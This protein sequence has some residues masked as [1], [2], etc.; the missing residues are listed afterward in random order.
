MFGLMTEWLWEING[1]KRFD[2]G[3]WDF[4]FVILDLELGVQYGFSLICLIWQAE[5]GKV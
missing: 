1:S 5:V 3:F 4:G 2:E